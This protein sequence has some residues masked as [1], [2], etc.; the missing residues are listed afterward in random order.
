[1][2]V[3]IGHAFAHGRFGQAVCQDRAAGQPQRL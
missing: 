1:M 2:V 3:G